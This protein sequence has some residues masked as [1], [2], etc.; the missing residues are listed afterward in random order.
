MMQKM[1]SPVANAA[2]V[3]GKRIVAH[4]N[5]GVI[6]AMTEQLQ[7]EIQF[8]ENVGCVTMLRSCGSSKVHHRTFWVHKKLKYALTKNGDEA[9]DSA[10]QSAACQ[11]LFELISAQRQPRDQENSTDVDERDN[12]YILYLQKIGAKKGIREWGCRAEHAEHQC[13]KADSPQE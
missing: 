2:G 13:C 1:V 9:K 4:A 3:N 10:Q 5:V 6:P 12:M 7:L 11:G 8:R